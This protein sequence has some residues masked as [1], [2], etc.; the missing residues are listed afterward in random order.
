[1]QIGWRLDALPAEVEQRRALARD[2]PFE[3]IRLHA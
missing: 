1:M 2:E 3:L